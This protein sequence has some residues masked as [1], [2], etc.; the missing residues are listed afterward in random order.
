MRF[1]Y[2]RHSNDLKA[3]TR[4]YTEV[5]GLD[6]IGTIDD[7]EGYSAVFLR[8][9]GLDW[10]LEFTASKDPADHHP[11]PE[12]LMVFYTGSDEELRAIARDS[13]RLGY[14]RRT[15]KNPY[16]QRNGIELLDPDGFGLV[17]SKRTIELNHESGTTQVA[18]GL[19]LENWDTLLTHVR[20][21]PYGRN[22][23]R[24]NFDL[25]LQEAKGTCSSK[26]ALLKKLADENKISGVQLI[27]AIYKMNGLNTPGIGEQLS[28]SGLAYVPE[29]HCYLKINGKRLDLTNASSDI[30]RLAADILEEQEIAPEQVGQYKIDFHQN[31][32]RKWIEESKIDQSFEE[33]WS[34]R[35][36]CIAALSSEES[37]S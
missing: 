12:D 5:I 7:H 34:I 19:G 22:A 21:L 18:K 6:I 20:N 30:N 15:S 28:Q 37:K 23:E 9:P 8:L 11:D 33:V 36:S 25:V 27:L 17:I 3:L 26:H 31:Y 29:A 10:H 2:A 32:L 16:W 4:F 24:T 14:K 13:D 35:E 1:R